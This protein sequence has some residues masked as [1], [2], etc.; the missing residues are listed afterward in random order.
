MCFFKREKDRRKCFRS[1]EPLSREK[2]AELLLAQITCLQSEAASI[3]NG[4]LGMLYIPLAF[5]GVMV[6]YAYSS[7]SP[8]VF[9]LLPFLLSW[10]IANLMKYTLKCF[11]IH[12]C[13]FEL[14]EKLN[15]MSGE[16]IFVWESGYN[17]QSRYGGLGT[18]VQGPCLFF[19]YALL[20]IEYIRAVSGLDNPLLRSALI[21]L[22]GFQ[23]FLLVKLGLRTLRQYRQL[24]RN[25][26]L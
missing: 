9:L 10:C 26:R 3:Q 6:Y 5:V 17:G 23:A 21:F 12:N 20:I 7:D 19:V 11:D 16:R 2:Q 25:S 18:F 24:R 4:F 13:V 1:P 22:L 15:R 8:N 14:E